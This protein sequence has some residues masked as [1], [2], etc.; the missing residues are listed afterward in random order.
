MDFSQ[1]SDEDLQTV[2][3]DLVEAIAKI[4]VDLTA[5]ILNKKTHPIDAEWFSKAQFAVKRKGRQHQAI[6][7]EIGRR[8]KE[9]KQQNAASREAQKDSSALALAKLEMK[10]KRAESVAQAFIDIAKETLP[11]PQYE[12]IM[13]AA[14]QKVADR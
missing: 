4:K 5:A 13:I 3:D 14:L 1:V 12:E 9:K 10:R 7:V 6:L 2:C 8:R 11:L